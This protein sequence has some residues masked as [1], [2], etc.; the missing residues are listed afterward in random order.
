[1]VGWGIGFSNWYLCLVGLSFC[2]ERG[3]FPWIGICSFYTCNLFSISLQL[4][5]QFLHLFFNFIAIKHSIPPFVLLYWVTISEF[6]SLSHQSVPLF[7]RLLSPC[8]NFPNCGFLTLLSNYGFWASTSEFPTV[9]F[10]C[11]MWPSDSNCL[12]ILY[13]CYV[14]WWC[15]ERWRS[16]I[17]QE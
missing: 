10:A 12:L 9:S 11:C 5:I 14:D 16:G 8:I 6:L 3:S 17:L 15:A 2:F 4:S 13:L 1:M 7:N